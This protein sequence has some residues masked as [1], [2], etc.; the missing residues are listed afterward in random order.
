MVQSFT[1]MRSMLSNLFSGDSMMVLLLR[2]G[3]LIWG[4]MEVPQSL[5]SAG[6]PPKVLWGGGGAL[7]SPISPFPPWVWN[8]GL[9]YSSRTPSQPEGVMGGWSP[10]LWR[11]RAGQSSAPHPSPVSWGEGPSWTWSYHWL[12][13]HSV[14][15]GASVHHNAWGPPS[16][17]PGR[18]HPSEAPPSLLS[19]DVPPLGG[20]RAGL[21]LFSQRQLQPRVSE[22]GVGGRGSD[23]KMPGAALGDGE[24][25]R[26]AQKGLWTDALGTSSWQLAEGA[27]QS[28]PGMARKGESGG[29]RGAGKRERGGRDI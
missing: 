20:P 5:E 4:L 25:Q 26:A 23:A 8:R 17:S 29:G 14:W 24:A 9:R 10:G 12:I 6:V 16:P 19:E 3:P 22:L 11:Q 15:A 27:G 2:G 21:Q 13:G 1:K 18:E 7:C 28:R